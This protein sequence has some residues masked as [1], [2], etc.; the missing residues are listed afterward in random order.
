MV[1]SKHMC[2]DRRLVRIRSSSFLKM[3]ER[4][5]WEEKSKHITAEARAE[6]GPAYDR[7]TRPSRGEVSGD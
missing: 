3:Q 2:S 7:G 6:D 1:Q 4:E 5:G